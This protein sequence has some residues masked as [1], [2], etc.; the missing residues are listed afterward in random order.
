MAD[1]AIFEAAGR[2]ARLASNG[3]SLL[4]GVTPRTAASKIAQRE[5]PG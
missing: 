5:P 1:S 3:M 2:K 4:R